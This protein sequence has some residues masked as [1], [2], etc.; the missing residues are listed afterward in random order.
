MNARV[1]LAQ[2]PLALAVHVDFPWRAVG[3]RKLEEPGAQGIVR[4]LH[5]AR[6][7]GQELVGAV[8]LGADLAGCN[9][10]FAARKRVAMGMQG[11]GRDLVPQLGIGGV[12]TGGQRYVRRPELDFL[13]VAF[14]LDSDHGPGSGSEQAGHA[15]LQPQ[16]DRPRRHQF[17]MHGLDHLENRNGLLVAPDVA[18]R[19]IGFVHH[20]GDGRFRRQLKPQVHE[21]VQGLRG[22]AGRQP[23]EDRVYAAIGDALSVPVVLLGA[24]LNAQRSLLARARCADLAR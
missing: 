24:V 15:G 13:A 16:I 17:T 10:S 1:V 22:A 5:E 21:P 11:V 7:G 20:P 23:P 18:A 8:D 3:R 19:R 9:D 2:E 12:T 4:V 6:E 14:G